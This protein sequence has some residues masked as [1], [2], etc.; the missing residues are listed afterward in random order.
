MLTLEIIPGH[1]IWI[2]N[3]PTQ[4]DLM[5]LVHHICQ[6]TAGLESLFL[7]WKSSCAFANFADEERFLLALQRINDSWFMGVRLIGRPRKS[8][9]E[10]THTHTKPA[11]PSVSLG[12]PSKL[13]I[14]HP[15][16]D[17][18]QPT[19]PSADAG[20]EYI[21]NG[22]NN[23]PKSHKSVSVIVD[24]TDRYAG[25]L[26]ESAPGAATSALNTATREGR[27]R[28]FILKSLTVDDLKLSLQ[29]GIWATQS[30][31]EE[32]LN[33]AFKV[34]RAHQ[35]HGAVPM[36]LLPFTHNRGAAQSC[37][38]VYLVFSANKSGEYFGYAKMKSEINEDPAA[39]I[40]LAPKSQMLNET[41]LPKAIPTEA[42]EHTPRG[43][44]I[45]DSARGTI[46]WEALD[47]DDVNGQGAADAEGTGGERD[48]NSDN[49]DGAKTPE[50]AD[51]VDGDEAKAW[52]KPFELE[53]LSTTRLPFFR[54]RGLRNPLN[55]NREVK[56]ARDGTEVDP[57]VGRRLVSLFHQKA[58]SAQAAGGSIPGVPAMP[59]RPLSMA[60]RLPPI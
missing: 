17:Q 40:E 11:R 57:A 36:R 42:T 48:E 24:G 50:V 55:A 54:T 56:I 6:L 20:D 25:S 4:T 2:G 13:T 45:D 28:Y 27:E 58:S 32:T 52:G 22:D 8:T 16:G 14:A 60:G 9:V 12:I 1:A 34:S 3:L 53:W 10:G 35:A 7:I 44:I 31:N 29:T 49:A 46:F 15:D 37:D 33:T 39:A 59:G 43:R 5:G 18:S 21:T 47:A 19:T 41:D 26:D 38:N 30:H 23:P 51:D